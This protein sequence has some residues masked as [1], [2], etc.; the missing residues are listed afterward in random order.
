MKREYYS[1]TSG[2][3]PTPPANPATGYPT[4]G[5][6]T[7]GVAPTTLG[8]YWAHMITE[9]L[10]TAIEVSGQTPDAANLGQLLEAILR[11]G[12]AHVSHTSTSLALNLSNI[13]MVLVDAS[14]ANITLTLPAASTL[15]HAEY[16]FVRTDSS[17]HTVTITADGADDIEGLA[18]RPLPVGARFTLVSGGTTWHW[19]HADPTPAGVIAYS[20]TAT[21]PDGWLEC[22]GS[23]ISRSAYPR[24]FAALGTTYGVGDGTTTFGLPDLRGEFI[25]ALD[26][27]RGVDPGR[28]LGSSQG[29]DVEPH[30]HGIAYSGTLLYS[31]GGGNPYTAFG[32][33]V[34]QATQ[35]STGAET[36]PRNIAL[37]A[38]I[39]F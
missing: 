27:G 16:Q 1:S 6:P 3:P 20:A 35:A 29:S 23:N 8:P 10:Q 28:T 36:R 32:G 18:S 26:S 11:A 2:T 13:G 19:P 4:Y 21:V 30:S 17:A 7:G 25:R 39:R 38:I 31:G 34:N 24:L 5:T 15:A 12:A 14:N 9:E 33:A 37:M 22:N